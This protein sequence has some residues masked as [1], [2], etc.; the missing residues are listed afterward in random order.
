[1]A[2]P[3]RDLSPRRGRGQALVE[4]ALVLPI[5][6]LLGLGA[7]DLGRVFYAQIT[8][9]NAAR[10]G[11]LEAAQN[12][13]SFLAGRD[14]DTDSNRIMCRVLVESQGSFYSITPSDVGYTCHARDGTAIPCPTAPTAPTIGDTAT[15]RVQG[16]FA[17]ITPLIASFTGGNGVTL[18]ATATTQLDVQ[19]DTGTTTAS[20]S[21]SSSPSAP[22]SSS[23]SAPASASPTATPSPVVCGIPQ[24]AFSVTPGSGTYTHGS[25]TGTSFTFTD[26]STHIAIE[27]CTAVW[28]W[29][30]GDGG[31][32][33][34]RNPTHVYEAHGSSQGNAY[35]V[36]LVVSLKNSAGQVWTNVATQSITVN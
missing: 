13:S 32:S 27:G 7:V 1:M 33:S 21:P 17:V 26:Q 35:V 6:L 14:C 15:V 9:A 12:P 19:P 24:V 36:M 29:T 16:H 11:A 2:H 3:D 23:P 22:P 4:L 31:G 18:S 20:P 10:E 25:I 30:F 8:I 34:E 5:F 28:G